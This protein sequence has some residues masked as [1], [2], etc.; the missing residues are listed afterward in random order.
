MRSI[1]RSSAV[2]SG[3]LLLVGVSACRSATEITLSIRTNVSC[4]DVQT[5]Q[6]VA[7]YVGKPGAESEGQAPTLVTKRCTA[8]GEIG[9]LVVVP[10][11]GKDEAVG[12]RVVA[13]VTRSP[14]ECLANDYKGCIVARRAVRFT[15]HTDLSLEVA[16]TSNCQDVACDPA[17]SC[18]AGVCL[19]STAPPSDA[20][21]P[22]VP[23]VRCG[24]DGLFCPTSG[25]VCCLSVDVAAGKAQGVCMPPSRCPVGN[26]VLN[27]DDDTDCP[28]G[29]FENAWSGMCVLSAADDGDPYRPS[30]IVLSDCRIALRE[31]VQQPL[32]LALC[33]EKTACA[34]G[35]FTCNA[36]EQDSNLLPNYHWCQ[37][38]LE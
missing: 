29:G 12:V 34:D 24:D 26:I 28:R 31:S 14:E 25:N 17:R 16:L 22:G 11:G 19:A 18:T 38:A 15:P 3:A 10:S 27:C 6:G 8:D 13:G 33:E 1:R 30:K 2:L 5:W 37:W 36:S 32:G 20:P 7:V 35:Q 9:S 23:S 4:E 21:P